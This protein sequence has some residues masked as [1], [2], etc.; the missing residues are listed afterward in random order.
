M[1]AV[2]ADDYLRKGPI[3]CVQCWTSKAA[4]Y[5]VIVLG[6]IGL[7]AVVVFL[8]RST[9]KSEGKE[10]PLHIAMMK[11]AINHLQ[12]AANV[13]NW[14][15]ASFAQEAQHAPTLATVVGWLPS[16]SPRNSTPTCRVQFGAAGLL[17]PDVWPANQRRQRRVSAAPV[18][19]EFGGRGSCSSPPCQNVF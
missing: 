14:H 1:C 8:V 9:V 2:C 16:L 3:D 17:R 12:L 6:I 10:P 13:K 15:L 19:F 18:G 11:I 5:A 7:S 4:I